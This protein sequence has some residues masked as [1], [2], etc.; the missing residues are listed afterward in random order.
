MKLIINKDNL[1]ENIGFIII[2]IAFFLLVY[3]QF[4][5]IPSQNIFSLVLLFYMIEILI[6]IGLIF[7]LKNFFE[8]ITRYRK[9]K[10]KVD[11]L[12][13]ASFICAIFGLIFINLPMVFYLIDKSGFHRIANF[14]GN[15][16][17]AEIWVS[18]VLLLLIASLILGALSIIWINKHKE[19]LFG[20]RLV[21]KS[22]MLILLLL[23]PLAIFIIPEIF[24]KPSKAWTSA[25]KSDMQRIITAQEIYYGA[26]GVYFTAP[27]SNTGTHTIHGCLDKIHE[28]QENHPDYV[29]LKND[30]DVSNCITGEYF[31]VYATLKQKPFKYYA[32]SEKFGKELDF[33]PGSIGGVYGIDHCD[34]WQGKQKKITETEIVDWKTYTNEEYGFEMIFPERWKN[35]KVSEDDKVIVFNLKHKCDGDYH[36]IFSIGIQSKEEWERIFSKYLSEES[37]QSKIKICEKEEYI[38]YYV[39]GHDDDGYIGFPEIIPNESYYGPFNDVKTKI[40]P[41]FKFLKETKMEESILEKATTKELTKEIMNLSEVAAKCLKN[42]EENENNIIPDNGLSPDKKKLI[43]QQ[44][45]RPIPDVSERPNLRVINLETCKDIYEKSWM[46]VAGDNISDISWSSDSAK[47]AIAMYTGRGWSGKFVI[48]SLKEGLEELEKTIFFYSE[49]DD[50]NSYSS[51]FFSPNGTKVLFAGHRA[52]RQRGTIY[53]VNS[54][55][56][57]LK[58][59]T[60]TEKIE[61]LPVWSHNGTKII[62]VTNPSYEKIEGIWKYNTETEDEIWIMDIDGSDKKLLAKGDDSYIHIEE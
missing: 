6:I 49:Q 33:I 18:V 12:A 25:R 20:K 15:L 37:P 11:I 5:F 60:S 17:T 53:L 59:L 24:S 8:S 36:K 27:F 14:L 3:H 62:Y 44:I 10:K 26:N 48:I 43:F 31:C 39:L 16:I 35:Y 40:I 57:N 32:V 19:K 55:G 21:K 47:A 28:R 42:L 4:S 51:S 13:I 58:T 22:F 1:K 54:D 46:G 45:W 7:V 2:G 23:L 29:W 41:T 61:W 56:T 9:H 52:Y 30:G 38:F 50:Y 34:C